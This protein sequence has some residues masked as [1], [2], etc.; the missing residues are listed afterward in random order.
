[1]KKS[2]DLR[3][4]IGPAI[5]A[6]SLFAFRFVAAIVIGLLW[7]APTWLLLLTSILA[8][9]STAAWAPLLGMAFGAVA[10]F[11][12]ARYV[13]G[14]LQTSLS[15][16]AAIAAVIVLMHAVLISARFTERTVYTARVELAAIGYV[17]KRSLP[18]QLTAQGLW[19]I[20]CLLPLGVERVPPSVLGIGVVG[21]IL[22]AV[23]VVI[24][25]RRN[26]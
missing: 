14:V 4:A 9:A 12:P 22:L 13:D 1:M 16:W 10:Q 19:A 25:Q 11:M 20:A 23:L 8:L 5:P 7:G 3:L 18:A 2:R 24:S 15:W 17:V 21:L 26:D 6:W